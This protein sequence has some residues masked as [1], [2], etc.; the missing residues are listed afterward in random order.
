MVDEPDD[1]EL[2]AAQEN[3]EPALGIK[4]EKVKKFWAW[5]FENDNAKNR[6]GEKHGDFFLIQGSNRISCGYTG[7]AGA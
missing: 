7:S 5:V 3:P 6:L 1:C 2:E 4:L